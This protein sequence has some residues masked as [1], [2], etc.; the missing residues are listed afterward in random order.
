MTQA[1]LAAPTWSAPGGGQ[2]GY[3]IVDMN[4]ASADPGAGAD[5]HSVPLTGFDCFVVFTMKTGLPM[6]NTDA[7]CGLPGVSNLGL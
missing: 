3:R 6:G 2:D 4:G 7:G 5:G 1:R